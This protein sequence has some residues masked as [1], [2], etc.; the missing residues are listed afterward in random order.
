[1]ILSLINLAIEWTRSLIGRIDTVKRTG[2]YAND[3]GYLNILCLN[4]IE[5]K[6]SL[7]V[8]PIV[9]RSVCKKTEVKQNNYPFVQI[10]FNYIV[11]RCISATK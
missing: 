3:I 11:T 2:R 10:Y 5:L 7:R 6:L 1:M 4:R 9:Q 8:F